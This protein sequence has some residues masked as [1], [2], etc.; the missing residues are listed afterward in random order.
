[1]C[2]LRTGSARTSWYRCAPERR[3]FGASRSE[4]MLMSDA[5]ST[6]AV[7]KAATACASASGPE[8][9]L[10]VET[11]TVV[12]ETAAPAPAGPNV[13]ALMSR[14]FRGFLPVVIDVETGG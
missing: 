4:G 7:V 6:V 12:V 11:T 3:Y 1:M 10:V 13:A 2:R 5:E 8:S 9:A 14:R